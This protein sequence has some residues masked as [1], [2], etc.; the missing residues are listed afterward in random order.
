MQK[1]A[2]MTHAEV[3]VDAQAPMTEAVRESAVKAATVARALERP[4]EASL[5]EHIARQA[6][7]LSDVLRVL[8]G[9][10]SAASV[11]L[12]SVMST[13]DWN[14]L[15]I[16]G[17]R[18]D[19]WHEQV[20]TEDDEQEEGRP[21]KRRESESDGGHDNM[22]L[23]EIERDIE[24][25][26]EF[27]SEHGLEAPDLQHFFDAGADGTT[28][29]VSNHVKGSP[30]IQWWRLAARSCETAG[31]FSRLRLEK[32]KRGG[33]R[34]Q[35][36]Y[37]A[38]KT[39]LS[40]AQASKYDR[41]GLFLLDWPEF[42]F[43]TKLVTLAHWFNPSSRIVTLSQL[44]VK[45]D[46][47]RW[48]GDNGFRLHVDGF[49]VIRGAL[50][51]H[52]SEKFA[53]QCLDDARQHGQVIFNNADVESNVKKNDGLRKQMPLEIHRHPFVAR[54]V[55][56]LK[57]QFPRHR[58]NSP[59][60]LFSE[61]GCA[62]QR[63]HTDYHPDNLKRIKYDS[64]M[65]LACVVALMDGTVFDV[66]PGAI[67]FDSR[68]KRRHLQLTLNAGDVLIFRG[69]LVHAGAAFPMTANARIHVYLD[70]VGLR[71]KKVGKAEVTY[72]MDVEPH[73]MPRAGQK[74]PRMNLG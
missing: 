38:L 24:T 4:H 23:Q 8:G 17:G 37:A 67:R 46:P 26:K 5:F 28:L 3:P 12:R 41:L 57:V 29:I 60:V 53:Q 9:T 59:V 1:R 13:D 10:E 68:I 15:L 30:L 42:R 63:C 50:R 6:V 25:I 48:K 27:C 2:R 31:I 64:D 49:Q 21:L 69:D 14:Q 70:P 19:R 47:A 62:P 55:E 51:E 36:R 11:V 52:V 44:M 71:R 54:I 20:P 39:G 66:W 33:E 7:S 40:F 74:R 72:F 43:Q 73:I 16:E 35:V 65:P 58:P 56:L 18:I 45:Q 22:L 34:I 61:T 32:Q